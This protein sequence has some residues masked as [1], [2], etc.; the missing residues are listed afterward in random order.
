MKKSFYLL[1]IISF[2]PYLT[3]AQIITGNSA[4][5]IIH[6]SESIRKNVASNIPSY[7]QFRKNSEL[8]FENFDTWFHNTFNL[9]AFINL[10]LL[11]I[12]YD[13]EGM[14]H[15]RYQQ[16]FRD[17][18]LEGTMFIVHT[19]DSKV[20]SMNGLIFDDVRFKRSNPGI[21]EAEAIDKALNYTDADT[22][23]WESAESEMHLKKMTNDPEATWFPKGEIVFA[24]VKGDYRSENYRLAYKFDVFSDKPVKRNFIFVDANS[25]EIILEQTRIM[26]SNTP[27]NGCTAYSGVQPFTSDS[28]SGLYRLREGPTRGN[29]VETYNMNNQLNFSNVTDFT[30]PQILFCPPDFPSINSP[31]DQYALDAHWGAEK[32]WDYYNLYF[33][34]N[35]VDDLGLKIISYVHYGS[36]VFN[37]YW[38][39]SYMTYGDAFPPYTPLTSLEIV[40]HEI[41]HGVTQFTSNLI[42]SRESGAL[43]ES[44]SDC[45]GVTIRYYAK[46]DTGAINWLLG[47]EIGIIVR[48]MSNPNNVFQPDTYKGNFWYNTAGCVPDGENDYCG[49]HTNSGVMNYWYYLMAEGGSGVNDNNEYY[50]VTGIG[51]VKASAITYRTQAIYNYPTAEFP[52]AGFFSVQAASDLYG[53]SSQEVQTVTQAWAAVGVNIPSNKTL[54]IKMFIQGF[55]NAGSNLMIPDTVT[56]YLRN[57]SSPYGIVDSVKSN[58]SSSGTGI[59]SFSNVLNGI[60]YYIHIKH[61]NSVETWSSSA[62][63]FTSDSMNYNFTVSNTQ[64]FGSN[65]IQADDSPVVFAIYSGDVNQNGYI[66]LSDITTVYNEAISFATGYPDTDVTGDNITDLYDL[67][68]TLNNSTGFVQRITP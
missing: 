23:M 66:D 29:G 25:G 57:N 60:N 45:M 65:M 15:Y 21:S 26:E 58:L 28:F 12:E 62:Q 2:F 52:E 47:N 64:A 42:Y 4:D 61:R 11:N 5:R 6:G 35:S 13:L 48:D 38:N 3:K 22:Y 17:I 19:K 39:G 24:P 16:T 33:G 18:P 46:G 36:N 40:G 67:I 68:I 44:F 43:N 41:S 31:L 8:A 59:F 32:T 56:V 14:K 30:S 49:V 27:S 55:Y 63:S 53:S 54:N 20:I 9:P 37:A 50:N 34:R 51:L 10:K 1:L 7:L